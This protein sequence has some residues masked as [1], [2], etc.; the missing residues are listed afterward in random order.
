MKLILPKSLDKF[1]HDEIVK[2]LIELN[3]TF[4][5]PDR[6]SWPQGIP[7]LENPSREVV[8]VALTHL[9][10]AW[11]QCLYYYR[12][13]AT[14]VHLVLSPKH[15][16]EYTTK[17]LAFINA[18]PI[19]NVE[20][21]ALPELPIKSYLLPQNRRRGICVPELRFIIT[22]K[23]KQKALKRGELNEKTKE[24]LKKKQPV[25]PEPILHLSNITKD[26]ESEEDPQQLDVKKLTAQM[27]PF[28]LV[29]ILS[30]FGDVSYI[31]R[32]SYEKSKETP[33][34]DKINFWGPA[35]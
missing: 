35:K 11:G 22:E 10:D 8:E 27:S 31:T 1:H 23:E 13:G 6:G 16:L 33:N 25:A 9:R 32:E 18:N 15:Y 4:Y 7:D 2:T 14:C 12:S 17:E 19:P 30:P 20:V 24:E 34:S 28:D 5:R 29:P 3:P 21:H 26:T